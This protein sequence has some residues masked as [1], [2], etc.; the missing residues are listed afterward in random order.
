M[1]TIQRLAYLYR[2][3]AAIRFSNGESGGA[4]VALYLPEPPAN[5]T[6]MGA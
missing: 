4:C 6:V 5:S 1:N 3:L 2:D